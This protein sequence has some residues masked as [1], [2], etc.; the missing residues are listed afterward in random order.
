MG[1]QH[2][3]R[4][5]SVKFFSSDSTVVREKQINFIHAEKWQPHPRQAAFNPESR[6]GEPTKSYLGENIY[7]ADRK[8][9]PVPWKLN[10]EADKEIESIKVQKA[11]AEEK[12]A[13]I[14]TEE[15]KNAEEESAVTTEFNLLADLIGVPQD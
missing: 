6:R 4:P 11:K 8:S 5:G 13:K 1:P 10:T 14:R 2:S 12:A 15:H 3:V 7:A 9:L